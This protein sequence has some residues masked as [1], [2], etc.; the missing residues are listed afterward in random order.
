[1]VAY[2]V[3]IDVAVADSLENIDQDYVLVSG[4]PIDVSVSSSSV[5][6]SKPSNF[7]FRSGGSIHES[8]N[9]I[10]RVSAPMPIIGVATGSTCQ[11]G[12]SGSLDSAPGTSH[13]SM[14]TG[15]EQPSAHC[16]TRIKSLQQC[17]STI[18]ELVNE[19]VN[20]ALSFPLSL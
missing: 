1:M 3:C 20:L 17:A 2:I 6:A 8:S 16:M 19:K 11:I 14:D 15:D 4:P 7:P 13:A 12:S 9:I 18:T 10:D 5:S